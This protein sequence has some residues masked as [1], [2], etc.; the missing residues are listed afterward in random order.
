MVQSIIVIALVF[1]F[2]FWVAKKL[3]S[4]M[5]LH[6]FWNCC[7]HLR[8][9]GCHCRRRCGQGRSQESEPYDLSRVALCHSHVDSSTDY[10]QGRWHVT[11]RA[12][13]WIGG[14]IDTTG[15]VVAAVL[16]LARSHVC[17]RCGKD[18][19]ECLNWSSRISTGY[20]VC[21]KGREAGGKPMPWKYGSD[22]QS[23]WWFHHCFHRLL[24]LHDRGICEGVT[25]LQHLL[26]RG[27][28]TLPSSV[29]VWIRGSKNW[30][31]WVVEGR[32]P[33]S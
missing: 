16:S 19:T 18:G 22:F 5:N 20:M 10:C 31:P 26:G 24:F 25:V 7:F 1:Y 21:L 12:G 29:L 23:L 14:T 13:A 3:V 4:T 2:C 27:G 9:L 15:A 32:L 6:P 11:S 8:R 33:L 30:W 28:L 17:R